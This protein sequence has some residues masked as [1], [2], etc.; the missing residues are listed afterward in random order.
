MYKFFTR[1]V[2]NDIDVRSWRDNSICFLLRVLIEFVRNATRC[3][4]TALSPRTNTLPVNW[5]II[6]TFLK[7]LVD[8]VDFDNVI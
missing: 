3:Y 8:L 2:A 4:L 7:N 5:I 1:V 6:N